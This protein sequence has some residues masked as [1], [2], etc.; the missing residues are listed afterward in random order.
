MKRFL[1]FILILLAAVVVLLTAG[2]FYLQANGKSLLAQSFREQLK[3]DI[4]FKSFQISYP[5]TIKISEVKIE[6][7]GTAKEIRFSPQIWQLLSGRAYFARIEIL[8][9]EI[10]L[11]KDEGSVVSW[12]PKAGVNVSAKGGEGSPSP[13][14]GEEKAIFAAQR[15][16]VAGGHVSVFKSSGNESSFLMELKGLDIDVRHLIL[17]VS[18]PAKTEFNVQGNIFGFENRFFGEEVKLSGWA[19]FYQKDMSAKLQLMGMDKKLGLEADLVSVKNDMTV[20]GKMNL[21]FQAKRSSSE[22]SA[23]FGDLFAQ[24]IRSSGMNIDL[25]FQFRTKMDDFQM[26][27]IAISGSIKKEEVQNP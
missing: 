10:V 7:Y 11:R 27:Q 17:F 23:S 14:Q 1:N 20:K 25:N 8:D 18:H 22:P 2:Y 13:S 6:G 5:L 9:P 3:V 26:S 19:D 12:I 15:I 4:S 21:G 16:I 24:A